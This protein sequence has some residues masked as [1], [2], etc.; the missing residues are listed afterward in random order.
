MDF[1]PRQGKESL[2][3][4]QRA[5]V[6]KV[7]KRKLAGHR[8]NPCPIARGTSGRAFFPCVTRAGKGRAID[9]PRARVPRDRRAPDPAPAG[10]RPPR[11]HR[12]KRSTRSVSDP[13]SVSRW[14]IFFDFFCFF[15][16]GSRVPAR[17]I[18]RRFIDC[19][20]GLLLLLRGFSGSS[21]DPFSNFRAQISRWHDETSVM[22]N[23][24]SA[25][26]CPGAQE[27][28]VQ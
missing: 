5:S 7:E 9:P 13:A 8:S 19:F 16:D 23:S 12:E 17:P 6:E 25:R 28:R 14:L 20:C 1:S 18:L 26:F 22:R 15:F 27:T 10:V 21:G 11:S 2:S 4:G 3:S 24:S